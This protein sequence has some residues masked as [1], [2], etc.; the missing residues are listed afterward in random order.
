M[1]NFIADTKNKIQEMSEYSVSCGKSSKDPQ[2]QGPMSIIDEPGRVVVL[3]PPPINEVF[4]PAPI[5]EQGRVVVLEPPPIDEPGRVVVLEPPPIPRTDEQG[6][7][8]GQE[9]EQE[10]GI[11]DTIAQRVTAPRKPPPPN[12]KTG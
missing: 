2:N 3:E 9:D 12:P 1:A 7:A 8:Q 5:D 6:N 10:E 11:H 4:E